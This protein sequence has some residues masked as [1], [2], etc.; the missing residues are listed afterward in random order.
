MPEH[1]IRRLLSF[2]AALEAAPACNSRPSAF[3]QVHRLWLEVNDASEQPDQDIDAFRRLELTEACGWR[4]LDRDPCF[5]S[6]IEHTGLCLYLHHD[7]SIVIQD[8]HGPNQPILLSKPGASPLIKNE[9]KNNSLS[10]VD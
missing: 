10:A 7:G 6:S 2:F 1:R 3:E 5:L 8:L 4:D 9:H